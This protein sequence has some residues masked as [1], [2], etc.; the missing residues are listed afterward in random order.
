[1]FTD[2][3][4]DPIS[5]ISCRKKLYEKER[6]YAHCVNRTLKVSNLSHLNYLQLLCVLVG[7][8]FAA[9]NATAKGK[10]YDSMLCNRRQQAV[11]IS[12]SMIQPLDSLTRR[13]R[14]KD[15][16][17]FVQFIRSCSIDLRT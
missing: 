5:A 12:K 16:G 17:R 14:V 15:K 4:P 9:S 3:A 2:F 13:K 10:I 8:R 6:Y 1:M 7:G 11:T